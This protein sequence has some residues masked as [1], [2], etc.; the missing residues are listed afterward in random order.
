MKYLFIL[1][2]FTFSTLSFAQN[3]HIVKTEDGRRVLLKADFTWEYIDMLKKEK[4]TPNVKP[5]ANQQKQVTPTAEQKP[6]LRKTSNCGVSNSFV[7]PKLNAKIQNQLR[8]GRATIKH[9]KKKVA[10]DNN[11]DVDQVLLLSAS[12]TKERGRYDFCAN[13]VN[14]KYKRTGNS[15]LKS[16]K[17]F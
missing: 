16:M 15:I 10:K 8:K 1:F 11:C 4:P 3:N 12:E 2:F 5:I 13:G 9:I 6:M 7:E 17:I 14:V